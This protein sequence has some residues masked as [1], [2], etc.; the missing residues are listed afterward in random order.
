MGITSPVVSG[1]LVARGIL[2]WSQSP[3]CPCDSI[4]FNRNGTFPE[5]QDTLDFFTVF[6]GGACSTQSCGDIDFNNN[7]VYPE[8]AD[9]VAFLG[10]LAGDAC[11]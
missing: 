2:R 8:D 5:L 3:Q 1:N 6:A 9:V 10:V 11:P 4:D 7:G